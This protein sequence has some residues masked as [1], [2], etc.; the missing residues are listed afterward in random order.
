[1]IPSAY[2]HLKGWSVSTMQPENPA[3][4]TL[5]GL[6]SRGERY[7]QNNRISIGYS[8]NMIAIRPAKKCI[9][10]WREADKAPK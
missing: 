4:N 10:A 5:F 7:R 1:M 2:I 3:I 8:P 6:I 9:V